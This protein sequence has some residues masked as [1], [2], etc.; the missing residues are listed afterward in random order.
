MSKQLPHRPP[1]VYPGDKSRI[2]IAAGPVKRFTSEFLPAVACSYVSF[3]YVVRNEQADS[4]PCNLSCC[5]CTKG[6]LSPIRTL[7][8]PSPAILL[9]ACILL[10]CCVSSYYQRRRNVD[11]Y[12]TPIFIVWTVL[13]ICVAF[14]TGSKIATATL[15]MVPWALCAAMLS[16]YLFHAVLRWTAAKEQR[17]KEHVDG[18][19]DKEK[20]EKLSTS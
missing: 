4:S 8:D 3:S 18:G 20:G 2:S 11:A 13:V 12:Q 10:G 14:T 7:A 19:G 17:G 15:S 5:N 6:Y 1:G 16:S 9:G